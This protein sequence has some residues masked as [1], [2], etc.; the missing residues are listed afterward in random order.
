MV[1]TEAAISY[2]HRILDLENINDHLIEYFLGVAGW[3]IIL[4]DH[5]IITR[6]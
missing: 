6:G 4:K 5:V 2:G 1:A 3:D